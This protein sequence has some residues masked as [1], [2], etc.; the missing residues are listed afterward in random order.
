MIS[1][2]IQI[3][4]WIIFHYS[5][6]TNIYGIT[7][8]LYGGTFGLCFL[9][10]VWKSA[11]FIAI[12]LKD[13]TVHMFFFLR[14]NASLVCG[15]RRRM[16]WLLPSTVQSE[17]GLR[18]PWQPAGI[19]LDRGE[20]CLDRLN[21]EDKICHWLVFKLFYCGHTIS[22]QSV[23]SCFYLWNFAKYSQ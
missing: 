21:W 11:L 23:G 2:V 6:S 18:V 9:F 3:D 14:E 12:Q 13:L 4:F 17:D 19:P 10:S 20:S 16:R 1:F 22:F 8:P 15:M 7:K 5:K